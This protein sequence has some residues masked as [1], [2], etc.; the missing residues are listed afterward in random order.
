MLWYLLIAFMRIALLVSSAR[1]THWAERSPCIRT[2]QAAVDTMLD[3]TDVGVGDFLID[4]SSGGGRI[5]R[6]DQI[7]AQDQIAL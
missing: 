2:S 3:L 4:L 7:C 6:A 1:K 5:H